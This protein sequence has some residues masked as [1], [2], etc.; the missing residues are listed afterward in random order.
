LSKPNHVKGKEC[1]GSH[2][3]KKLKIF[4]GGH[5]NKNKEWEKGAETNR[6]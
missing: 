4:R 2:K 5:R 1:G 3:P 6:K